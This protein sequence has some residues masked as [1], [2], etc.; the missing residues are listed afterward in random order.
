M[1]DYHHSV[2]DDFG[3]VIVD[4][5]HNIS[6]KLYSKAL[7][8][9]MPR[10]TLGLS[11]TPYRDDKMDRV[12]RWFLGPILYHETNT[13]DLPVKVS[14]M[15]YRLSTNPTA[16]DAKRFRF[17]FNPRTQM[18][19][20]PTMISNLGKIVER[21]TFIVKTLIDTLIRDPQRKILLL[22][23]RICQLELLKSEFEIR[24]EQH[25]HTKNI[26]SS[27]YVGGMKPNMYVLAKEKDVLFATYEMVGEGFNLEK[28]NTLI[29]CSPR[30]NS[31]TS[32]KLQQFVGRILRSQTTPVVQSPL[33]G[34]EPAIQLH[35]LVIDIH[36]QLNLFIAQGQKRLEYYRSVGYEI[37]YYSVIDGVASLQSIDAARK[38]QPACHQETGEHT[39]GASYSFEESDDELLGGDI[40]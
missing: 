40:P 32:N 30:S 5:V 19:N 20:T 12:Y 13:I 28:L 1:K 16:I 10:Y 7:C 3:L 33:N 24:K 35:P 21:N 6:T 29:M 11:A 27:M 18:A 36:D 15:Q 38:I 14:M 34:I 39:P 31:K 4:E 17:I 9:M 26:T 37:S 8:R 23:G 2:F 22:G 25:D